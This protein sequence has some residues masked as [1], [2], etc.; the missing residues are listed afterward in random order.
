M[1]QQQVWFQ[2]DK[3]GK[4]RAYTWSHRQLRSFPLGVDEAEM[5][6]ATEQAVRIAGHPWPE[7]TRRGR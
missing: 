6:I 2:V 5:L 4:R 7:M 3:H 1:A